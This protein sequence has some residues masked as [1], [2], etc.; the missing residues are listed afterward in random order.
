M[1]GLPRTINKRSR[2]YENLAKEH[3]RK[4]GRRIGAWVGCIRRPETTRQAR[5]E[6]SKLLESDPKNIKAIWQMGVV[7]IVS[8]NPQAAFEPLNQGL[9]LAVQFD[10][11]EMEH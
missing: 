10:V 9:S 7:E 2:R 4:F 8:G 11:P 6:L 3:A 1:R 5:V